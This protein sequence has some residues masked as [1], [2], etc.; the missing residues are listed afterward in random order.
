M[1]KCLV[2]GHKGYIG[3]HLYDT[4]KSLGHE[5]I[6]IDYKNNPEQNILNAL[7]R[8]Q[9]LSFCPEYIFHMACLPRVGYSVEHPVETMSNNVLS[10]S[11]VLKFAK[12]IKC[13]RVIY[14]S[15]SAIL[16]NGDGPTNPYG[17]QKF[18][19]EEECKL[20]SKL[21]GLDTVS[22]RYFNVYSADQ[23]SDGPYATAISNYMQYIRDNKNPFITGAGE[24]RRDMV[25]VEDVVR[26]NIFAME[27][28]ENFNGENYDVGTGDNISLNKIKDI[29]LQYFPE[30]VFDYVNERPGEV[31]TTQGD[32]KPLRDLGWE[33][34]IQ[35]IK[36]INECFSLLK[37]NKEKEK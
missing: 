8:D 6:G 10:T 13:R 4:L 2:T 32:P 23:P 19:S 33:T 11:V 31:A 18:I 5:V 12:D 14:S 25:N 24:Q 22:L 35:I 16:G 28:K 26:A 21:Y 9:F 1:S 15:S 27:H 3:S 17:L 30:V 36:G 29:V 37:I 34:K 20:Y 7:N